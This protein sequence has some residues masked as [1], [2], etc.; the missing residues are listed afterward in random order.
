[1]PK[2]IIKQGVYAILLIFAIASVQANQI[3]S[4][5]Q[6]LAAGIED[7]VMAFR[8]NRLCGEYIK[9]GNY[10]TATYFGSWCL[11]LSQQ[12]NYKK[13]IADAHNNIGVIHYHQG[14]YIE[15]LKNHFA[16]L[17]IQEHVPIE[18]RSVGIKRSIAKSYN[19]I[20]IISFA[21]GNY[22]QALIFFSDCLKIMKE[23]GDNHGVATIYNNIGSI[24]S[25]MGKNQGIPS[26][27]SDSLFG[28]ALNHHLSA[29]KMQKEIGDKKGV[30]VSYTNIGNIYTNQCNSPNLHPA[31]SDSLFNRAL[32]NFIAS[33]KIKEEINDERGI[34]LVY[35]NIGNVY[36]EHYR[37]K[38]GTNK[39]KIAEAKQQ[40][41]MGL[42]IANTI[43]AN[44]L[45]MFAYE[46]LAQCD[47]LAGN[48]KSAY[49]YHQLYTQYKDT[50]FN[51]QSSKHITEMQT[52]YKTEKKEM[53][54]V[55]QQAVIE[56]R[57][58]TIYAISGT[59]VMLAVIGI[60]I[61]VQL[62]SSAKRK[63]MEL[64]QRLLRSQMNPHF[65]FNALLSIQNYMFEK[66][67]ENA[68][69]FLSKFASL[70]RLILDNSSEEYVPLI[71][72]LE[73]LEYYL[74]LQKLRYENKFN[75]SI[76]IDPEIDTAFI[77][78][79]PMLA[80][81]FIENAIE[82]GLNEI[83]HGGSINISF[84]KE[85][86]NMLFEVEDNGVGIY[87]IN[88]RKNNDSTEK[89]TSRSTAITKERLFYLNKGNRKKVM[90]EITDLR[91]SGSETKAGTKVKF[92]IP[93]KNR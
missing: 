21:Q 82:H 14:N 83:E 12:L 81:P 71:K 62:R 66:N 35:N 48:W 18:L 37:M 60:L 2:K 63:S 26:G 76:Y 3:D 17:K 11:Q 45:I 75:Y 89:H 92:I 70:I 86:K 36:L 87:Q 57:N 1:M 22:P 4:L 16:S 54:I 50:L 90:F 59:L 53:E 29:L 24:Y 42:N 6:L 49:H 91:A 69:V 20:G 23:I 43:N 19:N 85:E 41:L 88:E 8:L 10:D 13:G 28:Q 93:I 7:T 64:Q 84:K 5:K 25:S 38:G 34:A 73:T 67:T 33:L 58:Y 61:I 72:E 32:K 78:V 31:E 65:I 27:K 9:T 79:P 30:S 80:Q 40:L 46:N 68:A 55:T 15:S 39:I 74:E 51:E 56:K 44:D 77:L 47:S 52:K